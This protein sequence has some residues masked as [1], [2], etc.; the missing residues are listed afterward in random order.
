M[1]KNCN[2]QTISLNDYSVVGGPNCIEAP[3]IPFVN[4]NEKE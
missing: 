2:R 4:Y 3:I 1:H